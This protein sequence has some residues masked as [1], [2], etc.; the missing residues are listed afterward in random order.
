MLLSNCTI[1]IPL[2]QLFQE[3]LGLLKPVHV[4][5]V[6][7]QSNAG[8]SLKGTQEVTQKKKKKK[9]G[10]GGPVASVLTQF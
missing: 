8:D 4:D 10:S 3:P 6:R 2:V 7:S 9:M 5:N 1:Q